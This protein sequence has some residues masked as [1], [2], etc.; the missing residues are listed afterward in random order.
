MRT[1]GHLAYRSSCVDCMEDLSPKP[2]DACDSTI[3][4]APG[5][6]LD[7]TPIVLQRQ[8]NDLALCAPESL[9]AKLRAIGYREPVLPVPSPC[10][11]DSC[12]NITHDTICRDCTE[13]IEY[14]QRISREEIDLRSLAKKAAR[15]A[16]SAI[17]LVVALLAGLFYASSELGVW[18]RMVWP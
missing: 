2:H 11:I 3:V 4:V 18:L 6:M 13:E 9:A 8:A 10:A 12:P 7:P 5:P 14:M 15:T 16:W 17:L 1:C